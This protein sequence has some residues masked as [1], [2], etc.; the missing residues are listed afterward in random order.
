MSLFVILLITFISRQIILVLISDINLFF[1]PIQIQ[2]SFLHNFINLFSFLYR[3]S[4]H[5]YKILLYFLSHVELVPVLTQHLSIFIPIQS[6]FSFL[7][8]INLFSFPYRFSSHS[9]TISIC[10]L[11]H[12]GLVP[13]LT[14]YQSVFFSIQVQF[15]F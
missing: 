7:H 8:N 11:S 14:Q 3:F 1:I 2:F 10:F 5:S 13:I 6:Q 12:T 4:C 15:P 9:Y